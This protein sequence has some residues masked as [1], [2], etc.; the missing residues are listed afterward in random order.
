[1][2]SVTARNTSWSGRRSSFPSAIRKRILERDP[3][4]AICH[5]QTSTI[6]DHEP[7]YMTLVRL[8]VPDPHDPKYGQGLCSPCH[9]IKTLAEAAAG[10]KRMK[11]RREPRRHPS[12][13]WG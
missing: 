13:G 8:G 4:C 2:G 5:E 9:D 10:R 7:N 3:I 1:M 12:E 11:G 6:A